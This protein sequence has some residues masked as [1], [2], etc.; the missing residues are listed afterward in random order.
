M[1][2]P[3]KA[4]AAGPALSPEADWF[5]K[6][7]YRLLLGRD[8]ID[9]VELTKLRAQY[10][11]ALTF[12]TRQPDETGEG[13]PFVCV[14]P[15][16]AK[17]Q[18]AGSLP[19]SPAD[20]AQFRED[21]RQVAQRLL[22]YDK[23]IY[24]S[25]GGYWTYE[26]CL[27]GKVRQFHYTPDGKIPKPKPGGDPTDYIL[28]SW[29]HLRS[30]EISQST[31]PTGPE[32]FLR[33][34]WG[35]GDRCE[36]NG[37]PRETTVEVGFGPAGDARR[38]RLLLTGRMQFY[39]GQTADDM[40]VSVQEPASC[41]YLV[42]VLSP[43]LCKESLFAPRTAKDG[44][45]IKCRPIQ[46]PNFADQHGRLVDAAPAPWA[47]ATEATAGPVPSPG[48]VVSL[49]LFMLR[50]MRQKLEVAAAATA[51]PTP[52]EQTPKPAA[53]TEPAGSKVAVAAGKNGARF[54]LRDGVLYYENP[55]A[56]KAE[57]ADV[58]AEAFD[59]RLVD[60]EVARLN[61][62]AR[63]MAL[64]MGLTKQQAEEMIQE[65]EET[66]RMLAKKHLRFK[67]LAEQELSNEQSASDGERLG[68]RSNP[69]AFAANGN[70]KLL[71]DI[72]SDSLEDLG[73]G[74]DLDKRLKAID[75]LV[76]DVAKQL[77]MSD[78]E[79]DLLLKEMDDVT[80]VMKQRA[81]K[82][83]A[84]LRKAEEKET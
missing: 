71:M 34:V 70:T 6:P 50:E 29:L 52:N 21:K 15:K 22:E 36:L 54:T 17:S 46:R 51:T 42:K 81:I 48:E 61:N 7:S 35:G 63:E 38:A 72:F 60:A 19:S 41:K 57:T 55:S 40:L 66:T 49:R 62:M 84:K 27:R 5:S 44:A 80:E 3:S 37:L 18:A 43:Q 4:G 79:T 68:S 69:T 82:D 58:P 67:L 14:M 65:T 31:D 53:A 83:A 24:H 16:P 30:A 56:A 10:G 47:T 23:C 20:K 59:E 64:S 11:S 75:K 73:D 45:S 2:Q 25:T 77:G 28:G 12:V 26:V 13:Q 76:R 39:C 33:E 74:K 9:D 32:W 1:R 8:V 78:K